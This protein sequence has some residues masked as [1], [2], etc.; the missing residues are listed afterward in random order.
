VNESSPEMTVTEEKKL[1]ALHQRLSRIR[2]TRVGDVMKRDVI[3]LDS[4]DLLATAA[5]TLIENK[6]HGVIVMKD[7]KPWS[8]LSA[9]DLLHKSYVESFSDKMDYLRSSLSSLIEKPLLHSLKP[10][11]SLDSAARLFTAYGQRTIPVIEGDTLVGVIAIADL[12]R[13]YGR[14][15]GETGI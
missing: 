3:T 2:N 7:G 4:N 12:I 10:T 13:S 9:F 5:R 6:I 11:D 1:N 15:V 8:V 14:L